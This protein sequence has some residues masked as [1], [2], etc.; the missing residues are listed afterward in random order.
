MISNMTEKAALIESDPK[1]TPPLNCFFFFF[2]WGH[3][4]L[5]TS[6]SYLDT[7]L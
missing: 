2:F 3:Q 5:K 1:Q 7:L 4:A 6:S